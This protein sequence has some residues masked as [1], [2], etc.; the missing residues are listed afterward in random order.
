MLE[1]NTNGMVE[2]IER[3]SLEIIQEKNYNFDLAD[4]EFITEE[5]YFKIENRE[6]HD[7]A[8]DYVYLENTLYSDEKD[9]KESI[10]KAFNEYYE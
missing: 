4:I 9:L 5:N 2:L 7:P 3:L 6:N 1:L 8:N 10:E